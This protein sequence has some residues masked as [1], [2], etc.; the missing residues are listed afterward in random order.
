MKLFEIFETEE[1]LQAKNIL[2][3]KLFGY[4]KGK[5]TEHY[6]ERYRDYDRLEKYEGTLWAAIVDSDLIDACKNMAE[7]LRI[8]YYDDS[9]LKTNEWL[10]ENGWYP[11]VEES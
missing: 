9:D 8:Q 2:I 6:T 11:P 5:G 7:E 1:A 3:D 10:I 4:P